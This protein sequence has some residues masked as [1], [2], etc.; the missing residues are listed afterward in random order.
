MLR[1]A[2]ASA[3]AIVTLTTGVALADSATAAPAPTAQVEEPKGTFHDGDLE[4]EIYGGA[5]ISNNSH[6]FYSNDA[7]PGALHGATPN[8][9]NLDRA[10][11]EAGVRFAYF[12]RPWFG[13][14]GEA[15]NIFASTKP[16][17]AYASIFGF[18]LQAVFQKPLGD[19]TPYVA[20]GQT[21]RHVQSDNAVLGSDTDWP[22]HASVGVR[23]WIT[24]MIGV[25]AD[26]RLL[27]GPAE[28]EA[29]DAPNNLHYTLRAA[30]GEFSLGLTIRQ[31]KP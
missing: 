26:A 21:L 9:P 20:V 27:L 29:A 19:W 30:Y 10:D 17:G 16:Q 2:S 15:S 22:I 7:Y 5:F 24:P 18:G 8:R 31:S 6:Q 4:G 23:Y 11:G 12:F 1:L 25:R 13:L 3:F 28:G 14:E